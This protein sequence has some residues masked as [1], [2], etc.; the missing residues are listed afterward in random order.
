MVRK[1]E[2]NDYKKGGDM[3]QNGDQMCDMRFPGDL[4]AEKIP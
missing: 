1:L 4:D 3:K 2:K